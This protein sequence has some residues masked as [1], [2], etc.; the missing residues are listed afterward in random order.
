MRTILSDGLRF[1]EHVAPTASP[2]AALRA[3]V[4]YLAIRYQQ[5]RASFLTRYQVVMQIPAIASFYLYALMGTEPAICD[6]LCSHLE[7]ATNRNKIRFLVA[8][9]MVALRVA[10]EEWLEQEAPGDLVSLLRGYL[11]DFS[12]LPHHA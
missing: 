3:T 6:A 8:L 1:L 4:E 2:H 7:A 12:S 9:Y 10:L 11:D 5:E